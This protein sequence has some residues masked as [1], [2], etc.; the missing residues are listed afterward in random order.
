MQVKYFKSI[1]FAI[2]ET[3]ENLFAAGLGGVTTPPTKPNP[4]SS[5]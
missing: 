4:T 3:I 5:N 2:M 1:S